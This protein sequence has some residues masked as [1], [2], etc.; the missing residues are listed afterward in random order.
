VLGGPDATTF[1][2]LVSVPM[3][4]DHRLKLLALQHSNPAL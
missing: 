2:Q 1:R 3:F 4:S